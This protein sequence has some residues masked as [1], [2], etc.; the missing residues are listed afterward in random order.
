MRKC[1]ECK[2]L[3]PATEENF[4]KDKNRPLG[5]MYR[6]KKCDKKRKDTRVW[7]NRWLLMSD[8]DK[9]KHYAH[10]KIYSKTEMGKSI[11][12][13]F[14]YKTF[15]KKKGFENDLDKEFI[16]DI[17]LNSKCVY[18]GF[19]PTGLD[20]INNK[21]GHTKDNCV[22]C[23]KECNVAR[24]DNFSFDEMKIIGD[25]IRQIKLSRLGIAYREF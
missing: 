13:L 9:Q 20:R 14:A 8:E 21:N 6:C 23:C 25:A 17:R 4:Y 18:C 15:D 2:L 12:T 16:L 1:V 3:Y 22:P 24:N 7:A 19:P 11:S 10:A 5:L